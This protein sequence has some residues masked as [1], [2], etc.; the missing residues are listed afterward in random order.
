V[1]MRYTHS[2]EMNIQTYKKSDNLST[3]FLKKQKNFIEPSNIVLNK[4]E[5][6][7]FTN[8]HPPHNQNSSI[9]FFVVCCY[10]EK[11]PFTLAVQS[12]L[13]IS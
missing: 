7:I 3:L 11:I 4:K 12:Y 1:Q 2:H 9:Y 8:A 13:G 10:Y 5:V 6:H